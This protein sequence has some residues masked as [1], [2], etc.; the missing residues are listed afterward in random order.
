MKAAT[1]PSPGRAAK[2]YDAADAKLANGRS[3]TF[4]KS[5]ELILMRAIRFE[6]TGGPEA[7][8]P[9]ICPSPPGPAKC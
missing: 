6:K 7:L 8:Q 1:T 2:H 5:T 3:L 9:S 4:F